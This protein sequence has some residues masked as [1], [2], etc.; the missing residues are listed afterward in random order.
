MLK[1]AQKGALRHAIADFCQ[2]AEAA[3]ERWAY[4]EVRPYSGIGKAPEDP[5][6][7]DCSAYVA[8]V[9]NWAMHQTG[10]YIA[11]PLNEHYS[12]I[13]NTQTAYAFLRAHPAPIGKYLI[14][15][16]AEFGTPFDTI[17]MS[18]CRQAGTDSTAVFSSNG[19]QSWIFDRDAP[20][21]ISLASEKARQHLV[22]VYRH[23]ALL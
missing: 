15:D 8:L 18:V 10:I 16:I 20:E 2:R 5:H 3:R 7:D 11:D 9:F 17:H 19:H 6:W 14:G 13:G 4:V 1:P 22:G 23:P 12:G 21:P